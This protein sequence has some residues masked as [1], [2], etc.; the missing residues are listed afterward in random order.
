MF[1]TAFFHCGWLSKSMVFICT[2]C[3]FNCDFTDGGKLS[4]YPWLSYLISGHTG[5]KR[6]TVRKMSGNIGVERIFPLD[7]PFVEKIIE[8]PIR[9]VVFK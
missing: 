1:T 2:P 6:F 4:E 5:N 9:K 3:S 8:L 7:S